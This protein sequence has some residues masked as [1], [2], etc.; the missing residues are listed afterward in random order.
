MRCAVLGDPIAHSLSPVLHRAGYAAAGLDDVTY[1]AVRVPRGRPGRVRR[2]ASTTDVARAVADD[3]AQAARA[4]RSARTVTDRARLAG[5]GQHPGARARGRRARR[6]HRP[7]RRGR[8]GPGAVRRSGAAG[9]RAR[10]RR[11]RRLDRRWRC[12]TSARAAVRLLARSADRAAEA[13][14]AIAAHPSAPTVEVGA[15]ADGPVDGEVVVVDDPGR[16]PGRGPGG[17]LRRR[18][19]RLRGALRPVADA[20]RRRGGRTGCWSPGSTCWCTRRCSSSSCS[21]ASRSAR[22]DAGRGRGRARGPARRRMSLDA[23]GRR[24]WC[25]ACCCGDRPARRSRR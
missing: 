9:D 19:R 17:A 4:R 6:Q 5:G 8:R 7:A 22:R 24:R 15:L 23:R 1:D 11:D 25:A 3:A 21:P 18:T 2:P 16:R 10:R 12:A 14:A 13:A 20:A